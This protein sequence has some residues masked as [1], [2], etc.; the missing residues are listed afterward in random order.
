[1][2]TTLE[3]NP[4]ADPTEVL[5]NPMASV[6]E[7]LKTETTAVRLKIHWPSVRKTLSSD[8]TRQAAG[9]FDAESKSV[10]ASKKL[11]DTS[12]PA[13]RAATAVRK[14]AADY[15]KLNTLPFTEPGMRLIR[16][17]DVPTFDVFMTS[18]RAELTEAIEV[19]ESHLDEMIDQARERLGNLFDSSDYDTNL[20]RLFGIEW[21][22]PSC[23]PPEYLLQVSPHLYYGECARVQRRF[24]EAV[25]LAEQAF[26]DELEHLVGHLAE[27]L[28]GEDDGSPKIFR[29]TAV[30]NL[31]EFFDRF[32]RL[33]IRSDDQLDRLVADAR[34]IVGGVVPQELRDQSTV[35][36]RVA[37][38]LSR[39]EASLEGWMTD[40]PRRSIL[41]RSK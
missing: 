13:F 8:Q 10:S 14:Q 26:A 4:H 30:T 18:V 1:M 16:R 40:R 24:D 41:R 35:R 25:K 37:S 3:T 27:R 34:S 15:W 5:D 39:V 23:N 28:S 11:F 17:D 29:D 38:E 7:R 12:H 19:L 9:T 22:Y 36:R 31:L 2:S 21:D 32:Q 33:N 6:G 20:R